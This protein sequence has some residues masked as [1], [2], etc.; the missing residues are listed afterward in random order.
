M[1]IVLLEA[2]TFGLGRLV[3]AASEAGHR[4]CLLTG[5]RSIYAYE[6]CILGP[7]ALDIVEVDTTDIEACEALLR[8]IG[9]L[10]GIISSTDTWAVPGAELTARLGLPGPDAG[11]VRTLRDKGAVRALLHENG[12][13]RGVALAGP[14][15]A[16][17]AAE[18]IGF[19]LVVKD[20]AGTSSRGVWLIRD[21]PEL[22]HAL[23]EAER[24]PLKG[25]LI[26]EPFFSG[27]VYSAETVTWQGRTRLLGVH[28]RQLSPE[29][30]RREDA[31]AFPVAFPND[32]R[33]GLD[34]WIGRV[35]AAAGFRQGFAHTEFV[36]T[37]DGPEV[38]EINARIGGALV[39][40]ALCRSLG[41]NVYDA[42][43]SVALGKSPALLDD[44]LPGGTGVAFVLVYAD[45]VGTLSGWSGLD[46][47]GALPGRPEWF[48]TAD[49]GD[50]FEHLG[51]QRGCTGIVLTEG[52]TAELALHRALTAA[53]GI[54]PL[55]N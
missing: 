44:P 12:L 23:S 16:R 31:A 43:I 1:T 46:R 37:A 9:D 3:D 30:M 10:A 28:S 47:L 26:A 49:P 20:S 33:A 13:S 2:L 51:D 55:I 38:V 34:D 17:Q 18:L 14:L 36:L 48:P 6:L 32:E 53:G 21:R 4:L 5:D 11:A 45:R 40:E 8:E 50:R 15:D 24:T 41:T 27:P 29:P 7:D 35:L 22:D 39:G 54:R 52:P 19:P 42:M 25:H